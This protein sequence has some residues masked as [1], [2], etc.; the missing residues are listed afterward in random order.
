[1]KGQIPKL[2][3]VQRLTIYI[4]IDFFYVRFTLYQKLAM[5]KRTVKSLLIC[6]NGILAVE[7]YLG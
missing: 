1:M 6:T 4:Y 3:T 7:T 5:A 2:Q